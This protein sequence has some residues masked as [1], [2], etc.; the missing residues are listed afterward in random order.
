[1]KRWKINELSCQ[2]DSHTQINIIS[3]RIKVGKKQR[4]TCL[5]GRYHS[6]EIYRGKRTEG[7]L[8]ADVDL[9]CFVSSC[10]CVYAGDCESKH[11]H[12]FKMNYSVNGF[13]CH[14]FSV[15][16][17]KFHLSLSPSAFVWS[18]FVHFGGSFLWWLPLCK[19]NWQYVYCV[20]LPLAYE[21]NVSIDA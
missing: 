4:R 18:M 2:R 20:Q 12:T 10:A 1:M 16:P 7:K 21:L 6:I 11:C 9:C 3:R 14:E 13:T 8:R 19:W 17:P 15:A 5:V